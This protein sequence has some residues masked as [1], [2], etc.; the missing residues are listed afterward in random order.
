MSDKTQRIVEIHRKPTL[1]QM[2]HKN[3]PEVRAWYNETSQAIGPYFRNGDS[4]RVATGFIEM[5]ERIIL[6]GLLERQSTAADWYQAVSEFFSNYVTKVPTRGIRLNVSLYDDSQP[7]SEKNLPTN[8]G[9][10]VRYKHA[11]SHPEVAPSED[12]AMGDPTARFYLK[13][14]ADVKKKNIEF[15]E[16]VDKAD[17]LYIDIRKKEDDLRTISKLIGG[18]HDDAI[19]LVRA[20]VKA[21]VAEYPKEFIELV[22]DGDKLR[23]L[24]IRDL[25]NSGIIEVVSGIYIK[26][27]D[28][29]EL[30]DN[31]DAV[32]KLLSLKKN[33]ALVNQLGTKLKTV[34]K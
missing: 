15:S 32:I 27:D 14:L 1:I 10:Y 17:I 18:N 31:E 24:F 12:A 3:D 26:A 33:E 28:K 4:K 23:R 22:E 13:D 9:D 30:G 19:E 7:L 16:T 20:E 8:I 6:P 21:F 2:D 5:E 34:K 29:L 25:V 11:L